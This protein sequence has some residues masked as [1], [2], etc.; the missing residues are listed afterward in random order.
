M[1]IEN[2]YAY[3]EGGIV[4]IEGAKVS[5]MTSALNYGLAIFEGIRAYWSAEQERLLLFRVRDHVERL[6]RN[7]RIL[8]MELP[9]P[10]DEFEGVILE[11]LR[12]EDFREDAYI[13][14]LLYKSACE[15]G[16]RVHQNP[17]DV[18]VFAAPFGRYLNTT[19]GIRAIVSSWRRLADNGV[20]PRGKIAGAYV[21]SAL[22]KSEAVLNGVDEAIFLS[23]NGTVSEGSVANLFL[24][25]RGTVVTPPVTA[26]ILEGITRD[27]LIALAKE[28][29]IPVVERPVHRTE[30]YVS[31]EVFL[32]GT[33]TEVAPVIEIDH[34]AVGDGKPGPITSQLAQRFDAVVRGR[35]EAHRDWL[36]PIG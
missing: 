7:A 4:P 18:A 17:C 32:C 8:L 36:T 5:I 19:D 24:V 16:P 30:L 13:R 27:A 22:A 15:I 29:R 1:P 20:P 25:R 11:L 10:I 35:V 9:L 31:D 26:D 23:E 6:R 28:D 21:N 34:R 12:K 33:A 14:P 3:F 2:R